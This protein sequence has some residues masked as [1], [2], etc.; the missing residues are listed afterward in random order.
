MKIVL[1]VH[2]ADMGAEEFI[3]GAKSAMESHAELQ[4]IFAG[5]QLE[6]VP[7]IEKHA[8]DIARVEVVHASEVIV[9]DDNPT[10][11]IRQKKDSS[12]VVSLELT[13]TREDIAGMVTAG[14]TGAALTGATLKIG[15]IAGVRRAALAPVLP[16]F[17]GG[18]FC[19]IDAGANVESAPEFLEQFALMGVSYMRDVYGIQ[20]PRVALVSN[21]TEDKKGNAL[22][23][24]T[25]PLLKAL[26][27]N[28]VGNMEARDALSGNYD[29]L[30]CDG[31]VGN[32]LLKS[33]EGALSGFLKMIKGAITSTTRSKLGGL[34]VK[35][36]LKKALSNWSLD[37]LGA[38][39]FL[40]CNKL[41]AKAHGNSKAKEIRAALLQVHNMAQANLT[42]GIA[43]SIAKRG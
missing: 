21:G 36:A 42:K 34:L 43:E 11:A 14:N 18:R 25:F 17:D 3:L 12:M 23:Q 8:L 33:L 9:G 16:T 2:G 6:V 32:V 31:F 5:N 30:V 37:E 24:A 4:V 40:G 19:L 27:I 35:P 28:F 10:D 1:D 7:L 20:N 26:P 29:V 22:V 38:A 13:K 15:R 41:V 39:A